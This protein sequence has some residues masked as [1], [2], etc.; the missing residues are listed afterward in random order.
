MIVSDYFMPQIDGRNLLMMMREIRPDCDLILTSTYPIGMHCL[1]DSGITF[2]EKLELI[3]TV[4]SWAQ[5]HR[6]VDEVLV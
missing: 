6:C 1:V 3:K 2:V 4:S 5:W